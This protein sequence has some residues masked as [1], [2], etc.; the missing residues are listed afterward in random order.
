MYKSTISNGPGIG[1]NPP[2]YILDVKHLK[3]GIDIFVL[4]DYTNNVIRQWRE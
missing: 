3:V 1:V 4:I 2:L